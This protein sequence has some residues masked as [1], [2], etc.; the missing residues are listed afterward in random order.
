MNPSDTSK[1]PSERR[2]SPRIDVEIWAEE[3]VGGGVY[4]HRVT[5]LSRNGFFI[6]K[7]LPFPID[8]TV[9]VK[10]ELPGTGEKVVLT[11]KV[12]ENYRNPD[13]D[14]RGAGIRF[15]SMD[16]ETRRTIDF[17]IRYLESPNLSDNR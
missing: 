6:E 10:L 15:L 1:T 2:E 11:G 3:R 9:T 5:N 8:S 16:E 13:A 12:V 7:K 4:Y 14:I 17:C